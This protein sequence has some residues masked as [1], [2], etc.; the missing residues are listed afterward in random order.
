MCSYGRRHSQGFLKRTRSRQLRAYKGLARSH[1]LLGH[2]PCTYRTYSVWLS[3]ILRSLRRYA[4]KARNG[5]DSNIMASSSASV[6]YVSRE[7]GTLRYRYGTY[8]LDDWKPL[9]GYARHGIL[10]RTT[11]DS[12]EAVHTRASRKASTRIRCKPYLLGLTKDRS[13]GF[14]QW[15]SEILFNATSP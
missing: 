7:Q 11:T 1:R 5:K 4:P 9:H 15:I 2:T 12:R 13:K 14:V 3:I 8:I 10:R 6:R